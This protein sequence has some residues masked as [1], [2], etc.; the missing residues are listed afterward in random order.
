MGVFAGGTTGSE[1]RWQM[2]CRVLTP[3]CQPP[4]RDVPHPA[5]QH[6]GCSGPICSKGRL[7]RH[8]TAP[9]TRE[10]GIPQ[11]LLFPAGGSGGAGGPGL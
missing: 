3:F 2:L 9:G 7:C 4:Q 6:A 1:P 8:P 5:H 10:T 11:D